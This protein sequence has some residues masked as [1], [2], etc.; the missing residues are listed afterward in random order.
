MADRRMFTD[1]IVE[2]DAFT[3]L[4]LSSQ[5]L[6]FHLN[7]SADDDGFVNNPKKIARSIGASDDDLNLLI[8]KSFLLA[9]DKGVM[10]IKHWRMHNL[11]RKDRYKPTQYAAEKAMLY[12]KENG[13][14]TLDDKKGES[15]INAPWQPNGNQVTTKWQPN[16]NQ[17]ATQVRLDK[18]SIEK[19]NNIDA[20][21]EESPKDKKHKYGDFKH[22]LL[23]DDE[24]LKLGNDYGSDTRDKAI[25]FLD[26]YIEEKGYKSK[27][28]YL[29]IKRWVVDAVTKPGKKTKS[30]FNEIMKT[31]YDMEAIEKQ[32]LGE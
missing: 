31:D 17:M 8:M 18:D 5:A 19:V 10:V 26:A 2:S 3:D 7:M 25:T 1:K 32:L 13:A 21:Q 16:G 4:P 23:T 24:H 22:V 11:L 14:Y 6:Y 12:V 15:L 29:A 9:F 20:P 27:S 30:G 28:H